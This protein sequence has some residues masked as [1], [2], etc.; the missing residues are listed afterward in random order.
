VSVR[1][2]N[3]SAN[4]ASG[5]S[6]NAQSGMPRNDLLTAAL[7]Y[8]RHGWA[9]LPLWWLR[10]DGR[11]GCGKADCD[12][13]GKHPLGKLA[14]NGVKNATTDPA[15]I[16]E[17]WRLHPR[18]NVGIAMGASSGVWT[19]DVDADDGGFESL[20]AMVSQN[21]LPDT[22]TNRTGGG[23]EHRLFQYRGESIRNRVKDIGDGLDVRA[24]GGYI[25]VPPS[26][27]RTGALYQWAPGRG[28]DEIEPADAPPW[29]VELVSGGNRRQRE[30]SQIPNRQQDGPT[31]NGHGQQSGGSADAWAAKALKEECRIVAQMRK[32]GRN[33]QLNTAAL[34]LGQMVGGEHL[35]RRRVVDA[36]YAAATENN[37]VAD[38]GEDRVM[39][40]INSGLTAGIAQPREKPKP[41]PRTEQQN[42]DTGGKAN[43]ADGSAGKANGADGGAGK[44][45][46]SD[47]ADILAEFTDPTK[48]AGIKVPDREWIVEGWLPVGTVTS[49]YGSGGVGKSLLAQLL[50]TAV[51]TG[52]PFLGIE[53]TQ[54]KVLSIFCEDEGDELHRRQVSINASLGIDL[55]DLGAVRWQS[56]F[57]KPN[58]MATIEAGL[59]KM[60]EFHDFVRTAA[61]QFE[62]RLVIIDNIAQVFAGNENVRAEVTQFVN[63]LG[64]IAQE[65]NGAVLL[66]GHPGKADTSEY[67]GSTAWDACVRSRWILERPKEDLD[68]QDAGEL[69]DLR[70]LR[71]T[72]ANYARKDDEIPMR[73]AAGTFRP[74]GAARFKDAVDRIEERLQE[75]ADEAAFLACLD[76]LREQGRAVS[77]SRSAPTYAPSAMV[78]MAEA[79]GIPKRRLERAMERLFASK[80]IKAGMQIGTK[81]NRHPLVGIGRSEVAGGAA[82]ESVFECARVAPEFE[83][84]PAETA[85]DP[86]PDPAPN[87]AT[88]RVSELAPELRQRG[89]PEVRQ[90]APESSETRMDTAPECATKTPLY[91][92]YIEGGTSGAVPPSD[93]DTVKAAADEMRRADAVGDAEPTNAKRHTNGRRE[94]DEP[95]ASQ[96]LPA[97]IDPADIEVV[98]RGIDP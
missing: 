68:E 95:T 35:E 47:D 78:K 64:T 21:G 71:R 97:D 50:H 75:K 34:K 58:V 4:A 89:A 46:K 69:A 66:L 96:P 60:T 59:L 25:V 6:D 88:A 32:G 33:N 18:A 23:G 76:T 36:L 13:P 40:T 54:C 83:P 39:A 51:G 26:V 90:S 65:I 16:K 29:L 41:E 5:N 44:E 8:A 20:A 67:S 19:L 22:V 98:F 24:T 93:D 2:Q 63:S 15:T 30:Q 48:L 31:M 17:W 62:A 84:D 7:A 79:K 57:G 28:P 92:T 27:H 9:V 42:R 56:R 77:H 81:A 61:K 73:W 3:S 94:A 12:K 70:V 55:E 52:R 38:D 11:C 45:T 74:E 49:L 91:T 53:T 85:P 87:P 80:T 10:P 82:S 14:P 86:A 1:D 43:G 37:S 72:K